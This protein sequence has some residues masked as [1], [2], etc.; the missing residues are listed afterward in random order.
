MDQGAGKAQLLLHAAR[1]STSQARP[2][3]REAGKRHQVL[4]TAPALRTGQ[5]LKIGVK[6]KIFGNGQVFIEPEPLRHV[7]DA[8][9][10]PL[11]LDRGIEAEDGDVAGI[12][13]EE[14]GEKT[15][16]GRLAG[17]VG[18]NE[19]G[20]LPRLN[21]RGKRVERLD[22]ATS[23]RQTALSRLGAR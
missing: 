9:L 3:R 16:Q 13:I 21:G 23:R 2:E 8:R 7:A 18:S 10:H 12:R 4:E 5:P 17:A 19:T 11:G 1:E 20:D 15:H 14:T 6:R 22:R